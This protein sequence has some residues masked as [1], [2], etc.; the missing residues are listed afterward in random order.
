MGVTA[1]SRD[2]GIDIGIAQDPT[3]GRLRV[4]YFRADHG[5]QAPFSLLAGGEVRLISGAPDRLGSF[6]THH[7]QRPAPFDIS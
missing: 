7:E 5:F 2:A 3:D 1:E 6:L 4:A